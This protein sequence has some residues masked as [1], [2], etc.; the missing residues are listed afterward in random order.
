VITPVVYLLPLGE[1]TPESVVLQA[2]PEP[3]RPVLALS[4][5]PG[6]LFAPTAAILHQFAEVALR[7]LDT[8]VDH[9][10]QPRFAWR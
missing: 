1:L 3:G 6:L 10:E 2:G 4:P 7:G 8:R 5:P 9:F